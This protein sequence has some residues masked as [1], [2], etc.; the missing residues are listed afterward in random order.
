MMSGT[1]I[2]TVVQINSSATSLLSTYVAPVPDRPKCITT[3][4]RDAGDVLSLHYPMLFTFALL[5]TNLMV[6]V[7]C[8]VILPTSSGKFMWR[9]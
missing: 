3:T 8:P 7:Y 6:G 5:R 2:E 9:L 4:T 1:S